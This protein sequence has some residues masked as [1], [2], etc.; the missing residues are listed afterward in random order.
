LRV[1]AK[2]YGVVIATIHNVVTGTC[3]AH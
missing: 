3:H 1:F 2:K